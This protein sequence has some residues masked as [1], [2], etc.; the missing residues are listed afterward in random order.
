MFKSYR[1]NLSHRKMRFTH[2]EVVEMELCAA[3][4]FYTLYCQD[5]TFSKERNPMIRFSDVTSVLLD[6]RKEQLTD[7]SAL[8]CYTKP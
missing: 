1:I 7:F 2:E 5:L 4:I 8:S 3:H 6:S